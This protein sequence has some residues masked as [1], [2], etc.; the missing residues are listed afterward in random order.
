MKKSDKNN[1]SFYFEEY[2]QSDD[3][4]LNQNKI[5]INQDRVYLLF[6]IFFS[7]ISIF[8]IKIIFISIQIPTNN[9]YSNFNKS[10]EPL[11]S[12]I[13]DRNG[14][15]IARNIKVYHAGIKPNIVKNRENLILKLR[16]VYPELDFVKI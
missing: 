3:K 16:L 12:D 6:F 1:K 9:S 15:L 11:R 13:L 2:I 8:A 5:K 4:N 7:L 10:F 14:I